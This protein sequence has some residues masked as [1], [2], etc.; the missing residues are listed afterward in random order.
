MFL[1]WEF[2]AKEINYL[3]KLDIPDNIINQA[4]AEGIEIKDG[5]RI[6]IEITNKDSG[7]RYTG[8]LVVTSNGEVCIP[9]GIQKMLQGT[10]CVR[11]SLL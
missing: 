5:I 3:E 2:S 6:P 10:A 1:E 11:V 4:K 8:R 9:V 7:W